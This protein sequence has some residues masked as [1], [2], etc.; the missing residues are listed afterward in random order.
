MSKSRV[1]AGMVLRAALAELPPSSPIERRNGPR[2]PPCRRPSSTLLPAKHRSPTGEQ[3]F[4]RPR[5]G[6]APARPLSPG[7]QAFD[8]LSRLR[9]R[10]GP[11]TRDHGGELASSPHRPT[12]TRS[13]AMLA[14]PMEASILSGPS[15]RSIPRARNTMHSMEENRRS[16]ARAPFPRRRGACRAF[17]IE[18]ARLRGA[19]ARLTRIHP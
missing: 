18:A 2:R 9:F 4:L 16:T 8:I 5:R 12:H 7:L 11:A 19:A 1:E 13:R 3:T 6:A 17:L 15:A 10:L 14:H